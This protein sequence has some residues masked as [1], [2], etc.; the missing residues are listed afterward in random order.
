MKLF[1]ATT[2]VKTPGR[3]TCDTPVHADDSATWWL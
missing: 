2:V 1:A 3:K